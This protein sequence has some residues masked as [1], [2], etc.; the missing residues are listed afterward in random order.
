MKNTST[1]NT[2]R[3]YELAGFRERFGAALIDT[4]ILLLITTPLLYGIYGGAYWTSG[5]TIM[6]VAD[7]IISFVFPFV[8]TVAFWVYKS[9]T[10]GKI[11]LNLCVVDA[12][13]GAKPTLQQAVIRY[14]AYILSTLPLFVGYLWVIWDPKKQAFHDKLAK[15]LV[16]RPQERRVN[17]VSFTR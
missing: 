9:A 17:E 14:F 5:A 2:E 8:A 15:T 6:G 3:K 4:G 7:F 12:E 11:A 16:V 10:P 13:T 1:E